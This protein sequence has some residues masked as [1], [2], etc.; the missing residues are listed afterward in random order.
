MPSR[1]RGT[2]GSPA[3]GFRRVCNF[4]WYTCIIAAIEIDQTEVAAILTDRSDRYPPAA[5]NRRGDSALTAG[6]A[7]L[8]RGLPNS[9]QALQATASRS[10]PTTI[11]T[12]QK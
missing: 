2:N 5:R 11:N 4:H 8:G 9:G 1:Q 7:W 12:T 3:I 6:L 10:T